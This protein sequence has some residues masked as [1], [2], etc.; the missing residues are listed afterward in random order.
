MKRVAAVVVTYNRLPLLR[1]LLERLDAID[2]LDEVLVVDNASTDGT[3]E[4]LAAF[5]DPDDEHPGT[6][7]RA[8][9]LADN[10]GG[11]GGFAEGLAWAM[12]RGADLA[13]LMDDDG[14][15]A[16]DCLQRL[17]GQEGY[18][19]WGPVVLDESD[20]SRLVFPIRLPGGTKVVHDLGDVESAAVDGRI[21][22]I[23]IPFNGVLVTRELVARIGVP[24]AEFFIWGDDHEYRLRAERAG[25]RIATVVGA[26]FLH[27]SVG[28]LGT[29]M[30]FGQTTYNHSPSDL[31]HYCMARNNLVN[32]RTYR[33]LP[34]ALAFVVKT[35]WFY[36]FTKP[37]PGRIGL[38]LKAWW[39]ALRGDFTGHRAYLPAS[40]CDG[41][42]GSGRQF[43]TAHGDLGVSLRPVGEERVAVVVVTYNRAELLAGLLRGLAEL[44]RAPD[45]VI[46]VDNAST[47]HT[48][49]VLAGSSLPGLQVI[50]SAENLGGAGGFHAGV[51]AAYRQGFDR[52]WL[53]DDDVVPAPD[54]LSVLMAQD[55]DCLMAVRE[56]TGGDLAEY[57]ATRFDLANPLAIRPK[58]ASVVTAYRTRA[59]MPERVEL[60]NVAFEG[61]MIRRRVVE[62]IGLPD[63]SFFIFYDDVDFALRARRAGFRIWAVRDA[64]LI[65]QIDFS[66]QHDLAGWKGFYMYRNLFAVHFRYGA[67]PAVRAKPYAIAAAVAV[68]KPREARNVIRALASARGMGSGPPSSVD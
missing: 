9:T 64:R 23:V 7:V 15:P 16:P 56:S 39:A 53:M 31:K 11:A 46:V 33:G 17:L 54:C 60:E 50:T 43:V 2:G 34:H 26:R 27:P 25:A 44:E 36:L 58:T 20:P 37:R 61:F 49:Q 22:D 1:R 41:S 21:E 19:F 65:R 4:W 10:T 14:V 67:N 45:A 51:R 40:V 68:L 52:I 30:M 28:D 63:E 42:P 24:R 47:D 6:P 62:A 38:S 32:L 48:A 57:A 8:R 29:P 18:D 35:L 5:D 55:E 59:E 13:W 66:Q 3:G 12:E